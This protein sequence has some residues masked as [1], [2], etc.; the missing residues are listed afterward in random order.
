MSIILNEKSYVEDLLASRAKENVTNHNLRLVS[1]YYHELGCNNTKVRDLLEKF[2][3][4]NDPNFNVVRMS[5]IIDR[6]AKNIG[7]KKLVQLDSIPI[8]YAEIDLVQKLD[9]IREQKILF[10]LI[11][12]AKLSNEIN[13]IN[14]GWVNR[15]VKEIFELA[16]MYSMTKEKQHLLLHS[17]YKQGFIVFNKRIDNMNIKVSC[18]NYN[19]DPCLYINDYRNLGNQ[20][21]R[22]LGEP[23]FECESCGAVVRKTANN[24]KYC[25]DCAKEINRLNAK[26]RKIK[27]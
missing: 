11:C 19:S 7:K 20:Y 27:S 5:N 22:Y 14:L 17:L 9:S 4:R 3:I 21:L 24:M 16:N 23:Y 12:L 26:E 1:R 15:S 2:I 8:T 10:T 6:A 13:G 25:S 18:L